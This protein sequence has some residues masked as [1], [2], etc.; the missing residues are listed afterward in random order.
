[1]TDIKRLLNKKGWTGE[2]V[3]KAIILNLIHDYKQAMQGIE[4]PTELFTQTQINTMISSITDRAQGQLF[5]RYVG[6]NNWISQ[7]H[8]I[9]TARY[10]QV[11]GEINRL[12]LII[13]TATA[14]EDEYKYIEQL[15]A[16]M[17]QKQYD[18]IRAWKIEEQLAGGNGTDDIGHG[19]FNMLELAI[20]HF[21]RLLQTEP[22]NANPLKIIK[23]KYQAAPVKSQRILSRYNEVMGEGYYTLPDGRRSDQ[24]TNEE[25]QEALFTPEMKEALNSPQ[26]S[27][28]A[29]ARILNRARIIFDGGTEEAADVEQKKREAE[30]G[31]LVPCEWH[32]YKEPPKDLT[33]WE[34]IE[35]GGLH[36]Y[37]PALAGEDYGTYTEQVEDFKQEFPEL[38]TAVI[39]EIDKTFFKGKSGIA[40]LPLE[41]WEDTVYTWRELYNINFFG[42]RAYIEADTNIFG[43]NRRAIL[44]GIAILRPSDLLNESPRI[45]KRGYYTEPEHK[46]AF[47]SAAGLEQ[48]TPLNDEDYL[49]NIEQLESSRKIVENNYYFLLGYDKAIE[50][51]AGYINLPEF[52]IFK[53]NASPVLARI[54]A[55]ND[56]IFMLYKRITD[57]D[58]LDNFTKEQKLQVLK[59]YFQPIKG[60]D[61]IIPK[62]AIAEAKARLHGMEAFRVQDG[63]FLSILTTPR[64]E[65]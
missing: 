2:E 65:A 3:G 32:T 61:I 38:F 35:T 14:A 20:E 42:F 56:L 59:D 1:M 26:I 33:K 62:E 18:E 60:N 15:P 9:A 16:I 11:R 44:N 50:L 41:K 31:Y 58:Y 54:E 4:R 45:D 6:L 27:D 36:E 40:G 29:M 24:M 12:L 49:S 63:V 39:T 55:L 10:E 51:I 21:V 57:T 34:I 64:E 43:D 37:Y 52:C 23:K 13:S 7:N 19:V 48:F 30:K 17:T 28:I 46:N 5:N 25:W 22:R 47:S 8:A 53:I